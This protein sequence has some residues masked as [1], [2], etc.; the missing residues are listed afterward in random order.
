MKRSEAIEVAKILQTLIN[1]AEVSII[2]NTF[3]S[4]FLNKSIQKEDGKYYLH[5]NFNLN[6]TV[7][8]RLSSSQINLQN[9][10]STGSTYAKHIKKCFIA[11]PDWI[12]AGA[13][14]NALEARISALTSKDP[15]KLQVYLDGYD[16]HCMNSYAYWPNEMPDIVNTVTSINSIAEKYPK[17]RQ[18]SKNC[19]FALTYAGS[20][21]TL[22]NNLGFP[23]DEAKAI[24]KNYHKLYKVSDEW[25]Q[26]KILQA[27]HDGYVTVAFGLR[28]RTPILSQTVLNKRSTP[29]EAQ[30]ESRTAG[31]AL[32][33]SYGLL[34]N[35]AS[36]E[37]QRKVLKSKYRYDIKPIAQIHDS[38]YFLIRNNLGC[39]K[40]FNDNLIKCMEWQKLPE[41]A[42]PTVTL[43][44]TVELY[45]PSW[46]TKITI[47]NKAT[48]LEILNIS[49]KP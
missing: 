24:E 35:R 42:H 27:S 49:L 16:S 18:A 34:N 38:Q 15:A 44:G 23:M 48:K 30:A 5:G 47:P 4:A 14:F 19:T 3:V 6:G 13:D 9:L 32:G 39:I 46:N 8:G 12:F 28:V 22:V 2:L 25:V 7:S 10:P 20:Y 37:F 29:Y 1:I 43:G 45:H 31:N 36:I 33:Q 40:W 21:H 11:P 26:N 41:I 17:L